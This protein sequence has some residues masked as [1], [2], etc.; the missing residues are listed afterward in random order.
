MGRI[1]LFTGAYASLDLFTLD[2][3]DEFRKMGHEVMIYDVKNTAES[4]S[5]FAAFAMKPIDFALGYNNLG[6]NMEINPGHNVW[7]DLGVLFINVLMDHPFHYRTALL[8]APRNCA[9]LTCDRN[10]VSYITRFFPNIPM[11]A[12]LPHGGNHFEPGGKLTERS[13]D[14]FY[15]G[16]LS[17]DL[18]K[19]IMPVCSKYPAFDG[20]KM[21]K[22]VYDF[23]INNPSELSE[24]VIEQY[25]RDHKVALSDVELSEV[26]TDF[27]V[28][29]SFATSYYREKTIDTL[30]NNGIDVMVCGRGWDNCDCFKNPHFHYGGFIAPQDVAKTMCNSKIV[31]NTM[32]WFKDGSHDRVFNGMLAGAVAI[33]DSSGYMKEIITSG[34]NGILFEL[35]EIDRLP[36]TIES[37]LKD[38]EK[39]QSIADAGYELARDNHQMRHRAREIAEAFL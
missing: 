27:R 2:M 23:L 33:T 4:L 11:V 39:A 16:G 26:I 17:R 1:V 21:I 31:L 24:N 12:Y 15:A 20:E 28:V 19:E 10:H 8:S 30:V 35:P 29:D 36:K 32:T 37:L 34:T 13:I 38:I 22:E 3:A 18:V 25:M 7:E 14:V 6:F 9:V 5:R